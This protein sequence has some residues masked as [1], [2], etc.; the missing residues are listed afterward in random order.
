MH[1]SELRRAH[2][3]PPPPPEEHT[4]LKMRERSK[5]MPA[6]PLVSSGRSK[7]VLT[8]RVKEIFEKELPKSSLPAM[9]GMIHKIS[10]QC[11]RYN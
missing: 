2:T 10:L 8:D 7:T 6:K 9:L 3:L 4:P 5:T 11:S 1:R